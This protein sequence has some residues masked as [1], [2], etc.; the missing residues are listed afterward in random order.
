MQNEVDFNRIFS[1]IVTYH[2]NIEILKMQHLALINQVDTIIYVDN[3]SSN[4]NDIQTCLQNCCDEE[5]LVFIKNSNNL[6]LGKAQNIGIK[7][8]M[9]MGAKK[10]IIFDHDSIPEDLFVSNLLATEFALMNNGVKVAAIGPTFYNKENGSY[11]PILRRKKFFRTKIDTNKDD[12][13]VE[14]IIASGM[15][16]QCDVLNIVGLMNEDLF[17]DGIDN[18]W[19]AR[20]LSMGFEIY[21]SLKAKMSHEVGDKRI[22]FLGRNM[23]FHSPERRYYLCRNSV[24]LFNFKHTNNISC[25][26]EFA[27]TLLRLFVVLIVSNNRWLYLKYCIRGFNDGFHDRYGSCP[28]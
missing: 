23:S 2:P 16:I 9:E 15:L 25:T 17:V 14:F 8:A 26:I 10:V 1:I 22:R 12:V 24:L 7:K 19:C 18:E 4:F 6:G 5:K 20:A 3:G 27:K 28:L 11:Y 13:S 21:V